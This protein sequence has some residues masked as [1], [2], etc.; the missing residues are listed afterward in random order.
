MTN[1][2]PEQSNVSTADS[3]E[4]NSGIEWIKGREWLILLVGIAFQFIV[5]VAMIQMPLQTLRT[6]DKI[7][8]RVVPVDPRDLLRGDYVVLN[9][10]FSRIPPYGIPGVDPND[11]QG[12]TVFVTLEPEEDGK[13]WRASQFSALEPSVGKFI[14]GQISERN[15]IE[16]G[17]EA[18][19][20]QEGEG[21]K[22][23]KAAR[24]QNLSAEVAL[25]ENGSAVLRQLVIE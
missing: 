23:E 3:P 1:P 12:K 9:Y 7:L 4:M 24:M 22:Y 21:P 6:G 25:D 20:V 11:Q 15:L 13:H 10:E 14:R 8:F 18:Y 19:F 2:L 16:F 5:L 17:I